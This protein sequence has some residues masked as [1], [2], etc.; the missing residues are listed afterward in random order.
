[1]LRELSAAGLR[2]RGLGPGLVLADGPLCPDR[3]LAAARQCLPHGRPMAAESV[4]SWV[5]AL[6][7]EIILGIPTDAPWHLHV[8]PVETGIPAAPIGA[9]AVH[10]AKRAPFPIGADPKVSA[11]LLQGFRGGERRCEL[12]RSE[13]R[14][15]LRK[16]SRQ[17]HRNLTAPGAFGPGS[18]LVQLLLT[19]L[20]H[21]WLSLS[22]APE[23]HRLRHLI[24]P[25]PGGR[26]PVPVDK[27]AP[28]RAFAK[29]VESELRSGRRILPG[30]V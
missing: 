24:V 19:D 7:A 1:M 21:G 13:T 25:Y 23:L 10:S 9:R 26:L 12:I 17:R 3:R 14:A 11:T 22:P 18:H 15:E 27:S 6:A 5:R 20:R 16:N 2:G 30:E 8:F 29:L 28:S 4:G